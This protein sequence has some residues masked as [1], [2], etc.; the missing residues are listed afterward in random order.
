LLVKNPDAANQGAIHFHDIG[1]YLSQ[2]EKLKIVAQFGSIDGISKA[3]GW[4]SITPNE[5]SDW[6]GQRDKA[7]EAFMPMGNKKGTEPTLFATYSGGVKTNRDVWTN[8]S[9]KALVAENMKRMI[10]FYNSEVERFQ[11]SHGQLDRKRAEAL[12]GDFID[13]DPTKIS[14]DH[15]QR[16]GVAIGRE[17]VFNSEAIRSSLYRPFFPQWLYYDRFF[18]NRVYQMPRMFPLEQ[19]V[20]NLLIQVAGV[21]ARSFSVLMGKLPPCLDNI[22]KGQC[23][24]RYIYEEHTKASGDD[25]YTEDTPAGL[26]QRDALSDEGLAHFQAAYPG[27]TVT[28][29]DLFYYVYGLLHSEEYRSRFADNLSKELPRIPAVK[30]AKDFWAFVDAGRQLGNL[31]CD[32]E[33]VEPYPVTFEQGALELA[34]IPDPVKFYRVEKMKFHKVRNKEGKL[35]PDKSTIIYNSDITMTDIP[36][37]AYNYIVNGKAALDWVMERQGVKTD[38]KSGIVND[39][40]A[41]ANQTVG[42]PAYPLKL[43]R[44]VIT[45][46]LETMKIVRAL[47]K[48]EID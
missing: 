10:S 25:L 7:F 3:N 43:F 2:D 18:N 39:A 44:R 45:V 37:E 19:E 26:K 40:N 12:I 30:Q 15:A 31:H 46:S 22:E 8:N 47:P 4:K 32:Y 34:H 23:F 16:I 35:E 33:S 48:L 38:N 20:E 9:S 6:L 36:L 14:W 21:G 5:H 24:S 17:G 42:D 41:Y 28:K 1:D 29:D 27:E 13:S 11:S